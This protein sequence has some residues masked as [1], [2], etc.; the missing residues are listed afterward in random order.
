MWK[1]VAAAKQAL[2]EFVELG[3]LAVLA[4]IL[5]HLMLGAGAGAYITSVV[6]NVTKFTTAASSGLLG[7]VLV[8][9]I[10]YLVLR[11]ASWSADRPAAKSPAASRSK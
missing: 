3:F 10:V 5:I 4:L 11:R 9:A 2:W 1:F 7:I 6:D 8:L